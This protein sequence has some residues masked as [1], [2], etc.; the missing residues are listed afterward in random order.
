LVKFLVERTPD[1]SLIF[2]FV[3]VESIDV[4][5]ILFDVC[6]RTLNWITNII[7]NNIF[8]ISALLMNYVF[9]LQ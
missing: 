2:V 1:E 6:E 7:N 8:I 4:D 9:C 5:N 3:T